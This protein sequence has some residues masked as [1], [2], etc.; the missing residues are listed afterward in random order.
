MEDTQITPS[1]GKIKNH[2]LRRIILII[3]VVVVLIPILLVG[4]WLIYKK[5][6]VTPYH[7]YGVSIDGECP[8]NYYFNS[9]QFC[10]P[11]AMYKQ[12]VCYKPE[13]DLLCYKICQ[14]NAD[15]G[16]GS[17]CEQHSAWSG[18]NGFLMKWCSGGV[19]PKRIIYYDTKTGKEISNFEYVSKNEL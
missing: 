7:A 3:L 17:L 8:D 4:G 2:R 9:H 18:D 1:Q 5:F 13:G 15:C 6:T 14:T 10:S 12:V 16:Q 11:V 19:P